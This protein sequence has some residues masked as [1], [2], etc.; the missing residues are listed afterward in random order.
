MASLK[1]AFHGK[2]A[3]NFRQNFETLI[4]PEHQ[5]VDL[6]DGLTQP[7]EAAHFESAD[8]IV[9]IKFDATMPMPKKLRL[10][11]AP[12]AG[13]DMIDLSLLPPAA[14]LCNCHGHE[15][16]IAEYVMAALLLHE[17]FSGDYHAAPWR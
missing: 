17:E 4:C 3:T 15:N 10:Y 7:G 2:N 13:T 12:S 14:A 1:I 9:G 16:A 8:V 11:H 5:I 6:S